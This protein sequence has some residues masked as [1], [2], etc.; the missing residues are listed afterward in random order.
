M[1][2]VPT[3]Q[4]RVDTCTPPLSSLMESR[5]ERSFLQQTLIQWLLSVLLCARSAWECVSLPFWV[6][7][8]GGQGAGWR[9]GGS[10]ESG[11]PGRGW[12]TRDNT[13]LAH[14][15]GPIWAACPIGRGG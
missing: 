15:A 4:L 12:S 1:R 2:A 14:G 9:V 11:S 7:G 13:Q 3:E 10:S 5:G 8:K 6:S